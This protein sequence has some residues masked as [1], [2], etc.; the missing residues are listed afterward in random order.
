[1]KNSQET[2]DKIDKIEGLED[3]VILRVIKD[4]LKNYEIQ[5]IKEQFIETLLGDINGLSEDE[6][7]NKLV[8]SYK[9]VPPYMGYCHKYWGVKKEILKDKYNI[10]WYTP[11]EEYPLV[12]YD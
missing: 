12:I 7:L 1:M 4:D 10:E 9:K 5:G 8:E 11:S 3:E 6:I 2:L